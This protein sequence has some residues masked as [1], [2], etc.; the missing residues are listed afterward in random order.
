V[1]IELEGMRREE[2][3]AHFEGLSHLLPGGT[4]KS[5][6]NVRIAYLCAEI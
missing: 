2:V 1:N 6:K 3:V 5:H 4:E